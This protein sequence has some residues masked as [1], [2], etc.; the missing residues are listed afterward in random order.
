MHVLVVDDSSTIRRIIRQVLEAQFDASVEE[1][2][3][4]GD[5]LA[6][7]GP[8][9]LVVTDLL[10]PDRHGFSLLRELR[11][12]PDTA[13]V[14]VIVVS[15]EVE[16]GTAREALA[17]GASA[18]LGK[19]FRLRELADAVGSALGAPIPAAGAGVSGSP[20]RIGR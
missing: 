19:P 7:P 1:A 11:A 9:D 6:L 12:R 15:V 2:Q 13:R 20:P 3:G 4:V 5:A 16:P 14:P 18:F 17:A 10:L 8:F